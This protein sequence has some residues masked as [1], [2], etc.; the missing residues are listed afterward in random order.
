MTPIYFFC[1]FCLTIISVGCPSVFLVKFVKVSYDVPQPQLGMDVWIMLASTL[2]IL[3]NFL[4]LGHSSTSISCTDLDP[5]TCNNKTIFFNDT[6]CYWECPESECQNTQV[7]FSNECQYAE[8]RVFSGESLSSSDTN[9]TVF[10]LTIFFSGQLLLIDMKNVLCENCNIYIGTLTDVINDETNFLSFYPGTSLSNTFD[11][12]VKNWGSK[13][14]FKGYIYATG[15]DF[16]I[17]CLGAVAWCVT[18]VSNGVNAPVFTDT[19]LYCK[20]DDS[21]AEIGSLYPG[22]SAVYDPNLAVDNWETKTGCHFDCT[23]KYGC[24]VRFQVVF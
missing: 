8:A 5:P 19:T 23:D 4:D 2:L 24:K 6:F 18:E 3:L 16:N 1:A 17:H 9:L 14:H 10:T 13:L 20:I 21:G 7:Y 22:N 15:N 12:S 11:P